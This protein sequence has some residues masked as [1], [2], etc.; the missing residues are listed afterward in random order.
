MK[1]AKL[2]KGYDVKSTNW[3]I[4]NKKLNFL[5]VKGSEKLLKCYQV[6]KLTKKF[7]GFDGKGSLKH[8]LIYYLV[9]YI[10][11]HWIECSYIIIHD[12]WV[13]LAM[14]RE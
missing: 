11:L 9:Y 1:Y 13:G 8:N 4:E 2:L 6:F 7:P 12:S 3:G 14:T 5:A 10:N